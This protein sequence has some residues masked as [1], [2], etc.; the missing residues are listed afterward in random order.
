MK[1]QTA[2]ALICIWLIRKSPAWRGSLHGMR[3]LEGGTQDHHM[4]V[5]IIVH[6]LIIYFVKSI[7]S[8]PS[9]RQGLLVAGGSGIGNP[10]ID[11][12]PG[13]AGAFLFSSETIPQAAQRPDRIVSQ[14]SSKPRHIDLDRVGVALSFHRVQVVQQF[15]L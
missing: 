9:H 7:P 8:T 13:I 14:F 4:P 2:A 1:L 5:G 11:G 10:L 15:R 12:H 6:R 3:H